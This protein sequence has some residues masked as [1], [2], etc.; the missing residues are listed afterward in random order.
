MKSNISLNDETRLGVSRILN[1]ILAREYVLYATARDCYRNVSGPDFPNLRRQLASACR[2]IAASIDEIAEHTRSLG[3]GARGEWIGLSNL[4]GTSA[5]FGMDQSAEQMFEELL[6]HHEAL[7]VQLRCDRQ[8]CV[9]RYRDEGTIL[10]LARLIGQ[11][12]SAAAMLRVE[13][14]PNF[15]ESF[16][17]LLPGSQR[18]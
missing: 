11:H 7:L 9:V 16:I 10:F 3:I 18:L 15:V 13:L 5:D 14:H 12:Q 8:I 4:A 1:L 6:S 2:G 17:E